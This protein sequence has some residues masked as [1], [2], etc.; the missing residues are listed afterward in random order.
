MVALR[1][2]KGVIRPDIIEG[3]GLT[4]IAEPLSPAELDDPLM[5]DVL[6]EEALRNVGY[7]A[8][9][10]GMVEW[11]DD[12]VY[13]PIYPEG[14]D[15]ARWT[16]M[17]DLPTKP[18]PRTGKSY[19]TMWDEQKKILAQALKMEDGRFLYRQIV[20]CWMRGEGKSLLACMIQLWKFHNWPRQQIMLGANSKDQ[21]KFVHFDI[22]RDI[23]K[24]SPRLL[25][26]IGGNKNILEKEIRIKDTKG[27]IQSLL[28]S[29]SSFSGIVSN[30]TGYTFS[31]IFDMKNPKFYTQLH[32]SIRNIPNAL[33]VI[34]STVSDKLHILYKLYDNFMRKKTELLYFSY[35]SSKTAHSDDY[36][37]PN[38]D[39]KQLNDYE[40]NFPFGEFEKYFQNL[41]SAGA[42]QV[43]SDEM[44]EETKFIGI[45]SGL[46]NTDK[47]RPEL[48]R[49]NHMMEIQ[50]DV[51][52]KGFGDGVE[53]T[54]LKIEEI[55][56]RLVPVD[57]LYQL[58]DE[59]GNVRMATMD[60]LMRL[61]EMFDT[62]WSILVGVDF[63]DPYAVRSSA[64]SI[65]SLTAKGL[66]GS[67]STPFQFTDSIAAPKYIHFA[68]HIE[69]IKDDSLDTVKKVLDVAHTEFDGLD[70]FCTERFGAWDV[71]K[72]CEKRDIIFE[73][74]FPTYDRQKEA[75]KELL[76]T[77]REGRY[78]CPTLAV[79]GSKQEDILR[80][81]MPAFNHDDTK[82]WFGSVEKGQKNGVQD[83]CMFS[84]AWC[85][86]GGR[87]LGV[88]D[89]RARQGVVNFGTFTPSSDRLVANY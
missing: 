7:R 81:E 77:V 46:F 42:K 56:S 82:K 89:F 22:M 51:D 24:H 49:K 65:L 66:P 17:K 5:Q 71:A 60:D 34:D 1:L 72:W 88:D 19:R 54:Q 59:Y 27:D 83:D 70:T 58:K 14:E 3:P 76:L 64:R 35:R 37:N 50:A 11:V 18:H 57:T 25:K 43:F 63:S 38:M 13:V 67:R 80:E 36:W 55:Y 39:D 78:K 52:A 32:G 74:I 85:I 73:P 15:I 33:G 20:L 84:K 48:E 47:M 26:R 45:D 69:N 21:V 4:V 12:F 8:G 40:V 28:R 53:E 61:T 23:I 9:G 2:R 30:I 10:E 29:I 44:V 16:P 86:Y 79:P 41:W 68:L 87:N 62:D 6:T 31:E 75:F